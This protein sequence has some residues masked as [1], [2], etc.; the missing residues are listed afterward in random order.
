MNLWRRKEN[1]TCGESVGDFMIELL[2]EA[3]QSRLRLSGNLQVQAAGELHRTLSRALTENRAVVIDAT[4]VDQ[5]HTACAQILLAA[6]HR[7]GDRLHF[8]WDAGSDA[9]HWL[10][11]AGLFSRLAEPLSVCGQDP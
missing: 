1:V 6:R 8:E 7:F 11:E 3:T 2:A 9:V 5:L 10:A 4:R